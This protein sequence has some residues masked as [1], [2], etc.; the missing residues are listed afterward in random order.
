[1]KKIVIITVC[2]IIILITIF[3]IKSGQNNT[4]NT[5]RYSL[6]YY[7]TLRLDTL[8]SVIVEKVG[9]P[10]A[11]I[12]SGIHI[13]VYKFPDGDQVWLGSADSNKIIYV[14]HR[15]SDGTTVDLIN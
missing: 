8:L 11:D 4:T 14:K 7:K 2:I 9:Q 12:G 5:N 3:L 13:F 1:M 6:E 15:K 10:D